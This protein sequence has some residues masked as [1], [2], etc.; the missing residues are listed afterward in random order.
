[1]SRRLLAARQHM[2]Q[3][4]ANLRGGT[5]RCSSAPKLGSTSRRRQRCSIRAPSCATATRSSA[6]RRPRARQRHAD[7]LGRLLAL[8]LRDGSVQ[9]R[10]ES[11]CSSTLPHERQATQTPA[12]DLTYV[13]RAARSRPSD[14][15]RVGRD[16][17]RRADR[18][19]R[20]RR[21]AAGAL[22]RETSCHRD[23]G[24][25]GG[26]EPACHRRGRRR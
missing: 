23:Q 17:P 6:R 8:E 19:G 11:K 10:A 13:R 12:R 22:P 1:V 14:R 7:Q 18:E 4:A 5:A 25:P 3:T 21:R 16:R 15:D 20:A 9:S 24:A 26:G 2:T